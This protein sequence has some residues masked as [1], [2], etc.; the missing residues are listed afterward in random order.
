MWLNNFVIDILLG[1][2]RE[3]HCK[4]KDIIIK[5]LSCAISGFLN[6]NAQPSRKTTYLKTIIVPEKCLLV[7]PLHINGNYWVIAFADF[8]NGKF[9]FM[10]PFESIENKCRQYFI[11]LLGELKK[12]HVYGSI[13]NVW[14]KMELK[15]LYNYPIQKDKLNCVVYVLYYQGRP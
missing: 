4:H 12:N 11:C 14:P 3:I 7:M 13:G 8:R 1:L 15:I 10:D 6:N 9:Y 2:L 5:V